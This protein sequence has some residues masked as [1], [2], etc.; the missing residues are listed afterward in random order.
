MASLKE[1]GNLMS[2]G[3]TLIQPDGHRFANIEGNRDCNRDCSYCVVPKMFNIEQELTVE[4]TFRQ[5]DWLYDNGYR[6]LSYLGGEP[7]APALPNGRFLTSEGIPVLEHTLRVVDYASDKGMNVNVTTNGDYVNKDAVKAL[8]KAGLGAL[9]FSLHSYSQKGLDHLISG[10]KMAAE[11]GIIPTIQ[12]VL[13]NTRADDFPGIAARVAE[14]GILFGFGIVQEKGGVFSKKPQ[15][16]HPGEEAQSLIPSVDQQKE[17][18]R[19]LLR[20]KT[21]GMIRNSRSYMTDAPN[22]PNNSWTCEPETDTFIHI[23]AGGTVD[24]YS[25]IRTNLKTADIKLLS[26]DQTWREIKRARVQ[27]CGNCLYNCC[28][29]MENPDVRGDLPMYGVMALIKTGHPEWAEKWGQHAVERSKQL[30]QAI[31]WSFKLS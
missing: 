28:Y 10:A 5:V 12:T 23:G 9:S 6:M 13:T 1:I 8:K 17:V 7:L 31:D 25:D 22:Y 26:E 14:N 19:S 15:P 2:A 20:L 29:E 21:F 3:Q 30:E 16:E 4:E 11:E 18:F 24:V 27:S